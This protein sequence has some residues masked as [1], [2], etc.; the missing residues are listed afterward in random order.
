VNDKLIKIY[1][2]LSLLIFLAAKTSAVFAG[3]I[4]AKVDNS[5][6]KFFPP[7]IRQ[8]HN[9]CGQAAGAYYTF[10]YEIN[11]LRNTAANNDSRRYPTHFTYNFLNSG[12]DMGTLTEAGWRVIQS[13]GVPAIKDY[14][15]FYNKDTSYWIF[16]KKI[17]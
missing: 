2:L 7:I 4:P 11:C 9:S 16:V 5:R 14:G 1:A 6:K 3:T 10:T 13:V 12:K 15:T 17:F 8:L